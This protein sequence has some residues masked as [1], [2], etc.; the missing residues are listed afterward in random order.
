MRSQFHTGLVC[1]GLGLGLSWLF[2]SSGS[3][4][5]AVAQ[6]GAGNAVVEWEYNSQS[7]EAASIQTKLVEMGSGGWEVF[8]VTST[9]GMVESPGADG[10]PHVI[11][12]RFEVTAKRL[13]KK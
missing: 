4:Q 3:T 6:V 2:M 7:V 10:K 9:D 5:Q 8:S 13:K 11:S 12:Q 1:L